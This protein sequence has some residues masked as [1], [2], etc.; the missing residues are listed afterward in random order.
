MGL[1]ADLSQTHKT[2][3]AWKRLW[4]VGGQDISIRRETRNAQTQGLK[5]VD[6]RRKSTV[7]EIW[8]G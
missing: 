6:Q 4:A 1:C 5:K 8:F 3:S 2:A 7:A